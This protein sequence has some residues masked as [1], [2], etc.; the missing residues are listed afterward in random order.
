MEALDAKATASVKDGALDAKATAPVKNEVLFA[1][2]YSMS[3]EKALVQRHIGMG[4]DGGI[5]RSEFKL[6]VLCFTLLSVGAPGKTVVS[7]RSFS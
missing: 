3:Q 5:C 6:L 7:N 4:V 1:K 2:C